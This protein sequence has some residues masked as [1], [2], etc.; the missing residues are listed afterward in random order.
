MDGQLRGDEAID[1]E[2]KNCLGRPSALED[3]EDVD[4]G[5]WEETKMAQDGGEKRIPVVRRQP[6]VLAEKGDDVGGDCFNVA[7][8]ARV[9]EEWTEEEIRHA[10]RGLR[11]QCA[12]ER[13]SVAKVLLGREVAEER[14][15]DGI[16]EERKQDG[17]PQYVDCYLDDLAKIVDEVIVQLVDELEM[18]RRDDIL[19]HFDVALK[20]LVAFAVGGGEKVGADC[21]ICELQD[22]E[23]TLLEQERIT[24]GSHS[25]LAVTEKTVWVAGHNVDQ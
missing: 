24:D 17:P 12:V 7:M 3:S 13:K 25:L 20:Q 9:T 22:H 4:V 14:R 11:D 15:D 21:W 5:G 2:T 16:G 6:N 1:E 18:L 23:L 19:Q 10:F 8:G